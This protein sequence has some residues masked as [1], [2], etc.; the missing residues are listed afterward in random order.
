MHFHFLG[1][2]EVLRDRA[3][4]EIVVGKQRALLA[5]LLLDGNGTVSGE[6]SLTAL[7]AR[8]C[9]SR[10]RR[11]W[12]P[13]C[14]SCGRRFRSRGCTARA[15]LP[16][17][18]GDYEPTSPV[19]SARLPAPGRRSRRQ[20]PEAGELLADALALWRRPSLAEF[21]DL[22]AGTRRASRGAPPC[23]SRIADRSR[24]ALGHQRDVVGELETLIAQHP[25]RERL[26]G[27]HARAL[28]TGRHAEALASYQT[29]GGRSRRSSG[30]SRPPRYARSTAMLQQAPSLE[31]PANTETRA[32]APTPAAG[33][34]TAS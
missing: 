14:R 5:I 10:R 25:L 1:P 34:S 22:R 12:R 7:W 8:T 16:A 24:L 11:W 13:P 2:R 33:I 20:S 15:R 19:S 30:S 27:Q 9:R 21:A 31:L 32:A 3:P 29:S 6:H 23:R 4:A 17:R 26:R 18:G 28:S